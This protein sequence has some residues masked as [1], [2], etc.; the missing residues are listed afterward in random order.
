MS[1]IESSPVAYASRVMSMASPSLSRR[2]K[3]CRSMAV[4]QANASS[5]NSNLRVT[6]DNMGTNASRSGGYM[7]DAP[8]MAMRVGLSRRACCSD[9][10]LP[11]AYRQRSEGKV[12]IGQA[13]RQVFDREPIRGDVA[14]GR[15][16]VENETTTLD[17]RQ[18]VEVHTETFVAYLGY[19]CVDCEVAYGDVVRVEQCRVGWCARHYVVACRRTTHYYRAYLYAEFFLL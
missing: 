16:F 19:E 18:V 5:C 10:L 6:F 9:P 7:T 11:A 13:D 1:P 14:L 17:K 15:E 4:R 8:S 2:L 3:C 12:R